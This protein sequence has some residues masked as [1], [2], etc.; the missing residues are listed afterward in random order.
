MSG[1]C[2][3]SALSQRIVRK[4]LVLP[5]DYL[6]D[7]CVS[8]VTH[9]RKAYPEHAIFERLGILTFG[10]ARRPARELKLRTP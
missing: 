5:G 4:P 8:L 1:W 9:M 2:D 10:P 3:V 6:L 7:C